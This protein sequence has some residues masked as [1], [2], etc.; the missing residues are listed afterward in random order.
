[1][2]CNHC[3]PCPAEIDIAQVMKYLELVPESGPIPDS[4]RHHYTEMDS[5]AADCLKCGSCESICPFGVRVIERMEQAA[6]V[7]GK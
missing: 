3:L 4:L 5:P 2:Y 1:M 6:A 7:F